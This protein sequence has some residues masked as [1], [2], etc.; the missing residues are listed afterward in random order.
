MVLD[1]SIKKPWANC[2]AEGIGGTSRSLQKETEAG[3]RG[4]ESS[5]CF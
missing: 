2:C 3:E 4:R 5:P 1:L